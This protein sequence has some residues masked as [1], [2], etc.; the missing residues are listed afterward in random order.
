MAAKHER[1]TEHGLELVLRSRDDDSNNI[2]LLAMTAHYHL[3]GAQLA[4]FDT[5][6]WGIPWYLGSGCEYGYISLPYVGGPK[7]EWCNDTVPPTRVLWLIPITK[8]ER[9]FKI[10]TGEEA[11]ETQFDLGF[12]YLDPWRKPVA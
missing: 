4:Q 3:T 6:N 11:L 1:G 7:L 9:R 8:S 5:V 10:E 12:N 2:E